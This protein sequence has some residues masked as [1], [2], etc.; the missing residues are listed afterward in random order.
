MTAV[1]CFSG[2]GHSLAV[3]DFLAGELRTDVVAIS[4][5]TR[6]SA[7]MAVVVFPVYCQNI[8][9]VVVPFLKNLDVS[10]TALIATYGGISCGNVLWEAAHL[11]KA[12]VIAGACVSTGHSFLGEGTEFDSTAL[13]PLL[14]KVQQPCRARLPQL[15]KNP[16]AGF[17]PAWRSRVGLRIICTDACDDCNLCGE[18]CPVSA[19]ER[20]HI[21]GSCIRC[22]RCASSCPRAALQIKKRKILKWY[23]EQKRR[24][25]TIVFT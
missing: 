25:H 20:G 22:L 4:Q 9:S 18:G 7:E 15:P 6:S 12:E 16:F 13:L 17:F 5:K 3:A 8:P 1:Y 23:L 19:M 24:R 11:T 21:K 14:A 10:Y 2:S